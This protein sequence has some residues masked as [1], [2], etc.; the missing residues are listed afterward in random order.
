MENASQLL[1]ERLSGEHFDRLMAL[2]NAKLH[3]FVA[4]AI[5]LTNP[6]SVYVCTDSRSDVNYIRQKSVNE[7][8]EHHLATKGHTYHFDGYND[9]GRD[10]F[11]TRY[12]LPDGWNLGSLESIPKKGGVEEIQTL[13]KDIMKGRQMIVCFWC[14]GPANSDFTI[15]C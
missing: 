15:P 10:K 5:K 11:S 3:A 13:L 12:L 9:Q 14:L 1:K 6:K 4:E 2:N 7:G 8:E